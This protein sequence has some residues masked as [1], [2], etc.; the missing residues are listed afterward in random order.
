MPGLRSRMG[1]W[2]AVLFLSCALAQADDMAFMITGTQFGTI[3]LTTGVFSP[4]GNESLSLTGLGVANGKL[5]TANG[6]TLYQMNL[7][8]GSLTK[9][10]TSSVNYTFFGSTLTGLYAASAGYLYSVDPGTGAATQI[11]NGLL[12]KNCIDNFT[13]FESAQLSTNSAALYFVCST[14]LYTIDVSSGSPMLIGTSIGTSATNLSALTSIN[15]TLYGALNQVNGPF[16]IVSINPVNSSPT[17]V[18][19]VSPPARAVG[20]APLIAAPPPTI[21]PGGVVPI[22]SSSNTI[23]PGSWV[24]IYGTNFTGATNLWA[25]DFPP[26]LGGVTV[27]INSKLAYLWLVSPGQINL[28]APD[29][30]ATGTVNVTVANAA[31]SVSSTVT[32]EP[33]GPS[34]SL[35]N[36]KYAAALVL[37]PGAPGNSGS[38]YDLIGPTGALSFTTRP[39]KAG[40]TLV[41]YGVGFGPTTP[42]APAGKVFSGAAPAVS[43]PQV[44]IGGVPAQVTFAGVIEAGLFQLNVVVPNAGHGDQALQASTGGLATPQGVLITLQ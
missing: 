34:F 31:G 28:Q 1:L 35:F 33:Y 25:G 12:P 14:S 20:L 27:T 41:L 11:G 26:T 37:T 6:S 8:N 13:I 38:G 7:A 18:S 21:N 15:G 16:T 23:Q 30:A 39:V 4:I 10:G 29:D 9:V 22:F 19:T 17:K 43:L 3:D 24:S 2:C 44:T 40:E 42:P 5:Y 32:L 36:G